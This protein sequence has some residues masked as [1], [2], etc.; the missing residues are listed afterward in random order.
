MSLLRPKRSFHPLPS[1]QI[2]RMKAV[3]KSPARAALFRSDQMYR[4]LKLHRLLESNTA[5]L[6][7]KKV[8][9]RLSM[10]VTPAIRMATPERQM[11]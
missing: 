8:L 2:D 4:V 3:T 5:G 11:V 1:S 9:H 6:S 10:F 7:H